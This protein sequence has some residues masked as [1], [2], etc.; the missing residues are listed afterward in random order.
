M[1]CAPAN[2]EVAAFNGVEDDAFTSFAAFN[3][4]EDDA[5]TLK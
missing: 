1:P 5:F 3:G 4:V 2:F